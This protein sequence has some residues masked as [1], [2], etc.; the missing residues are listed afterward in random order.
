MLVAKEKM[1]IQ[2]A[3]STLIAVPGVMTSAFLE[4]KLAIGDFRFRVVPFDQIMTEVVEGRAGA[5]LIIHEG[6]LTYRDLGLKEIL[7]LGVWWGERTEG[8]PLPLG[9]NAIRRS[10]GPEKIAAVSEVLRQSILY[11]LEHREEAVR[12]SMRYARDMTEDLTDRF[13]G[14]YVNELTLD[15]GERGRAAV[16]RLLKEGFEAGL[17]PGPVHLEFA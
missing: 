5:G 9:G 17:V 12:H 14:M 10:L 2:E 8:L 6:Q 7:N 4:L 1:S 11:G 3:R 13:V 16:R 15:Y